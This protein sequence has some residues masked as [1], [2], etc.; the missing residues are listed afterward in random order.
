MQHVLRI[1]DMLHIEKC[2]YWGANNMY[3]ALSVWKYK[4]IVHADFTHFCGCFINMSAGGSMPSIIPDTGSLLAPNQTSSN[5]L[6]EVARCIFRCVSIFSTYPV[7]WLVG[8]SQTLSDFQTVD[9]VGGYP[10]SLSSFIDTIYS[11]HPAYA[12]YKRCIFI[13]TAERCP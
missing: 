13:S 11:I 4:F 12:S 7:S 8:W 1:P 10:W 5:K 9:L 3:P 2:S 6:G